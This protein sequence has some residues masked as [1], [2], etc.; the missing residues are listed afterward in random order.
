MKHFSTALLSVLM[1]VSLASFAA[2]SGSSS[3]EVSLQIQLENVTS[4]TASLQGASLSSLATSSKGFPASMAPANG[5]E[6]TEST[7][8]ANVYC[9]NSSTG[10][11]NFVY[12]LVDTAGT[13]V[14][15]C[16]SNIQINC[17]TSGTS[18]TITP[19]GSCTGSAVNSVLAPYSNPVTGGSMISPSFAFFPSTTGSKK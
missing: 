5:G 3:N 9:S 15:T 6:P 19:T 8:A 13:T 17:S 12:N 16:N 7:V 18:A 14:A 11:I 2:Q 1:G 10:T 4:Y